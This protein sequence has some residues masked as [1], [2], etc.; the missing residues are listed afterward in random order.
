MASLI[1]GAGAW[2]NGEVAYLAWR[3]DRHIDGCLGF[4]ITR[5]HETGPDA[6]QRRILPSWIAFTDQSN[7]NWQAQDTSVWPVQNFEWRDLTLRRSRDTTNVRP[8]DF[9]VRYAI[10]PVGTQAAGRTAIP[11]SATAP[12]KDQ[13]GKPRY[14]GTPRPLYQ[15][16]EPFIT[17]PI[18]VTHKYSGDNAPVEVAFTNGILSTQNLLQ[19]LQSAM[20]A[21]NGGHAPS[22]MPNSTAGLLAELKKQILDRKSSIRSFLTADA[23]SFVRRLVDRAMKEDGEVYLALYELHDPE[24]IDLLKDAARAGRIHLILS[25][26]GSTD[27]NP[28]G[29]PKEQRQPVVWDTENNDAR[30]ALHQIAPQLIQDRMFNNSVAIGHDKF[31]VYVKN[32][33]QAV[34][35]GSTNWTE[36]GL[37]TQSNNAVIVNDPAIAQIYLDFWH[38]LAADAQPA[39]QA[40]KVTTPK[41]PIVGA[42]ANSANQGAVLR[43]S[44]MRPFGPATLSDGK[45]KVD[46]WFSPN[47]STNKKTDTSPMPGDLNDVYSLMDH[48]RKAILFLTFMPGESGKQNIIGEAAKLAQDRP[49]LLV[50]GAISD[51]AALPNYVRP[52]KGANGN[53]N[54]KSKI[55]PPSVWWPQGDQSRI[56]MVRATAISTPFG[57]LHPELLTAGHAII[58]DKIVVVD[59]LDAENCAVITGS[60]NLGYKASYDNDENLLIIRGNR[61]LAVAYAVHVLDVYQHYLMRAKQEDQIRAALLAG[62][63]Q[64]KQTV[65]HGFLSTKDGWQDRF[66]GRTMADARTYFL[67]MGL[68]RAAPAAADESPILFPGA[69]ERD[70]RKKAAQKKVGRNTTGRGPSG[71]PGKGKKGV[72]RVG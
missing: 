47:T 62:K 25:T 63:P 61:E 51:P 20:H 37:C 42:K 27:P 5:V 70:A 49:D 72:R 66:L 44:N 2:C 38:R 35:T 31:A 58:H 40:L 11:P 24:L 65:A 26:A 33:P 23:L 48:A 17:E 71:K 67:G 3:I 13:E 39:R 60:H 19:Q 56:A 10:V 4:M 36:T 30:A 52:V 46:V 43:H 55:P 14:D 54:G 45:S 53:G 6:G 28:K 21:G 22:T 9:R 29:T 69:A 34:M 59:P 12:Y 16:G 50:L 64:P 15:I 41:G 57:D 8:I 1:S 32:G 7:P 68:G 18:N